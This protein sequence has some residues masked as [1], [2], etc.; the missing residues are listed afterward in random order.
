MSGFCYNENISNISYQMI[1]L[2][3]RTYD[4]YKHVF[5]AKLL[6]IEIRKDLTYVRISVRG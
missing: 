5:L 6:T 1:L 3:Q 2:D 4:G